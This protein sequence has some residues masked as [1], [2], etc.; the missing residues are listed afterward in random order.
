MRNKVPLQ[1]FSRVFGYYSTGAAV[2]LQAG[3]EVACGYRESC[4]KILKK[5][6]KKLLN[7]LL[8]F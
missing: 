1:K 6:V 3:R 7:Y 8:I 4:E 5:N 2:A